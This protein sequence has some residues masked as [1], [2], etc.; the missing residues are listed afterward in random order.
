MYYQKS[1]GAVIFYLWCSINKACK[2]SNCKMVNLWIGS[3]YTRLTLFVSN[4]YE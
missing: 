3:I 2:M 1:V 4:K